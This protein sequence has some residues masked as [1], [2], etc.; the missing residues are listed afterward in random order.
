MKVEDLRQS[1]GNLIEILVDEVEHSAGEQQDD[2]S[3]GCFKGSK[4]ASAD[5]RP[6]PRSLV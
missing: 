3:L 4:G 5:R 2:Y 6:N 1:L